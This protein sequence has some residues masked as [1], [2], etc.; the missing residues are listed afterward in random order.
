MP[1]PS[2]HSTVESLRPSKAKSG[3][4]SRLITIVS[5]FCA[6]ATTT[7]YDTGLWSSP[8][9][10]L[11]FK[12]PKTVRAG[13]QFP[14]PARAVEAMRVHRVEQLK[15]KLAFDGGHRDEGLVFGQVGGLAG[16]AVG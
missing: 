16:G 2:V 12:G 8:G 10:R 9:F 15:T 14:V 6:S 4:S 13:A 7:Y 3:L 1:P 5:N 11:A